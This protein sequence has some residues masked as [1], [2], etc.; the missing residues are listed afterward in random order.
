MHALLKSQRIPA[1]LVSALLWTGAGAHGSEANVE[2][3][4]TG[5]VL[6]LE[7]AV[8]LALQNNRELS[9]ADLEVGR[10][11]QRVAAARTRLLPSLS[12]SAQG[13]QMLNEVKT[14]FPQGS[15]GN[16]ADGTP[17]PSRDVDV[18][19]PTGFSSTVTATLS[20]PL[21]QVPRL[22]SNVRLQQIGTEIARE[23]Q[24]EQRHALIASVK[25]SYYAIL[26]TQSAI[27]ADEESL[28]ACREMERTVG[29]FVAQQTALRSDLLDVQS[30]TAQQELTLLKLR[31]ALAQQ[32]ETLN[33]LLGRDVQT[34]FEVVAFTEPGSR[35]ERPVSHADQKD[36]AAEGVGEQKDGAADESVEALQ[37]R[38]L[39]QRP[40]LRRS[41]LLV[42]QAVTD[43]R[44]K[45]QEFMP[46]LSLATNYYQ[47]HSNING[48]PDHVWTVGFQMTW[49]PF[50]WGRRQ[51]E[52]AE[53]SK[54]VEQARI[55]DAEN[56]ERALME[57]NNQARKL[58]EAREQVR[59]AQASQAAARERLRVMMD[60][61]QVREVLLKDGLEAQASYAHANRQVQEAMLQWLTAQ[62]DVAKAV[63][64]DR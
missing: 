31:N 10:A 64:E 28:K 57:V 53:K 61:Y 37:A 11:Q 26:Q 20:Q 24:R 34:P 56:R 35:G 25:G 49:N 33:L 21:T 52:V 19:S 59:V 51:R 60:R 42:R 45:Q 46:E 50:D 55:A 40:D 2:A 32:K 44:I 36:G 4:R 18:T 43:R 23:E 15:L 8:T 54:A 27:A 13:G 63:G 17:L 47:F 38:A 29:D 7:Q 9:I 6:T 16:A 1:L 22:R 14:H 62:A 48:V 5:D 12:L 58:R 41:S 39:K 3:T 30:R